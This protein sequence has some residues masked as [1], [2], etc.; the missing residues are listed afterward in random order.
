MSLHETLPALPEGLTPAWLTSALHAAGLGQGGYVEEVGFSAVGAGV[1]MMSE[2]TRLSLRWSAAADGA[3]A[4]V[5][6]K[7]A[8]TNPTNR[9]AGDGFHVY[10]R[11]VRFFSELE[12][13][14]TARTPL[15]YFARYQ[16]GNYLVLMEDLGAY[17]TGSQAEGADLA[18]AELAVD[19]LAR[20]HAPFWGRVEA[21]DWVP[22]IFRSYHADAL[23]SMAVGSWDKMVDT[24]A[25]HVPDSIRAAGPTIHAALPALQ[26]AVNEG[27]ATLIHGDFRL[28][29][30]MFGAM[31]AHRPI[32]ILDWQ[33][34]L[35]ARG[36][37]DVAVLLGQ[38]V[39]VPVRRQHERALIARYTRRLAELGVSYGEDEAWRDY[40]VTLMY[41]WCYCTTITGGL[42]GSDPRSYAWMS[43]CVARQCAATL[44]HDLLPEFAR[45]H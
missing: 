37:V 30:L 14:T 45:W 24:F 12:Q 40:R 26:A 18:D 15:C 38:N 22:T 32:I 3:P 13:L 19:E 29:N 27:P 31:P 23:Y 43:Q 6:A 28:D 10:E 11:E 16:A 39:H 35:R 1:G 41:L 4:T 2:L 25:D 5:I 42:D 7:Y 33:G 34:P 36:I 21:L 20:L 8:S 44:D 9:A 17:R